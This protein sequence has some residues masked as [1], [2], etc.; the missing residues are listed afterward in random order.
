MVASK[1]MMPYHTEAKIWD[2]DRINI[3]DC[4]KYKVGNIAKSYDHSASM[5]SEVI[6]M[7]KDK[8]LEN[9]LTQS[10]LC[11]PSYACLVY[12]IAIW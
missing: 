12:I 6:E 9:V 3:Q 5:K 2:V 11:R 4:F 10:N 7:L 1:H 8:L